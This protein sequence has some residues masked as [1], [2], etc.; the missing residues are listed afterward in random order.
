MKL[1]LD[2][3]NIMIEGA[4]QKDILG[5][6][7]RNFRGEK[8]K[9]NNQIVNDA[10]KRN[11]NLVIPDEYIDLLY[12]MHCHIK[13]LAPRDDDGEAP[14]RFVKVN[15]AFGKYPPELYLCTNINKKE[16]LEGE[17]GLLD[18]A[19][20]ENVDMIIRPYNNDSGKCSLYLSK[21]YFTIKSDP[22]TA[23]YD[24]LSMLVNDTEDD[25]E[26]PFD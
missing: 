6:S 15:V 7:F 18:G 1:Y 11:F 25:E 17:L 14:L 8:R 5:G 24:N 22:I 2:R 9:V 23:K 16:L 13:E 12:N 10:G 21:G 19:L 3:G 26:V 20:F 4:T